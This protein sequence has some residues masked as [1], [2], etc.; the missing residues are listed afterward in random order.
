MALAQR[1]QKVQGWGRT[2]RAT[3]FLFTGKEA[4]QGKAA[5][6]PYLCPGA[7]RKLKVFPHGA[8]GAGGFLGLFL[9]YAGT[10]GGAATNGDFEP[11][12]EY[13]TRMGASPPT[14]HLKGCCGPGAA[15][16]LCSHPAVQLLLRLPLLPPCPQAP[17][18]PR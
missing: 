1:V 13:E 18:R 7:C 14:L 4:T 16:P 2:L 15:L 6:A 5:M 9:T 12:P 11:A 10:A 17:T 3:A 8:D